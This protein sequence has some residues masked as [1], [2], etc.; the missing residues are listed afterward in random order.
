[1][2]LTNIL[3]Q[4]R[5]KI[6]IEKSLFLFLSL[7]LSLSLSLSLSLCLFPL[8]L[9][10][11]LSL[12][13]CLR[14]NSNKMANGCGCSFIA[15]TAI[16]LKSLF[17]FEICFFLSSEIEKEVSRSIF[18]STVSKNHFSRSTSRVRVSE[19]SFGISKYNLASSN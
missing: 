17:A 3:K 12:S 1:M 7:F 15:C 16:I 9:S 14:I 6:K 19:H 4:K 13:L 11:S 10:L 2:Y 8:F 5:K 18:S